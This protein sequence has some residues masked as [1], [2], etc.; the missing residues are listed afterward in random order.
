MP[1]SN[2]CMVQMHI[3]S[4]LVE[5]LELMIPTKRCPRLLLLICLHEVTYLLGF[6]PLSLHCW[7]L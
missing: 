7:H 4:L 5:V 3:G 2:K 1:V 6:M